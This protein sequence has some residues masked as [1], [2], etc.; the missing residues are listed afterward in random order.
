[1]WHMCW[2]LVRHLPLHWHK[3]SW[4]PPNCSPTPLTTWWRHQ[5]E[6]FSALLAIC[7]GNLP[8]PGE[9]PAH[10]PVTRSFDVF[11]DVRLNKWLSKQSWGWWF[12]TLWCPLWRH[13]NDISCWS[14]PKTM[15]KRENWKSVSSECVVVEIAHSPEITRV[16]NIACLSTDKNTFKLFGIYIVCVVQL[17]MSTTDTPATDSC[18][19]NVQ[20]SWMLN[21]FI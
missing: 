6:T 8:V 1:M 11:F 15:S 4:R 2:I 10:R 19:F 14:T 20:P 7:A 12:E 3:G 18:L 13:R 5:M 9:F 16:E 17:I 21:K